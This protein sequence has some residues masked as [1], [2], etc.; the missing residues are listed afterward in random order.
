MGNLSTINPNRGGVIHGDGESGELGSVITNGLAGRESQI[1]APLL[2]EE[3]YSQ[4]RI[5]TAT[6]RATRSAKGGLSS[7]V[8]FLMEL[9]GDGVSRLSN[10]GV[11]VE[12][13][14]VRTTDDNTVVLTSGGSGG[15]WR[16][17]RSGGWGRG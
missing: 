16:S 1:D 7:G 9:E 6:H 11:W 12:Q 14:G 17:G 15:R 10:N 4:S 8:V 3:G 5:E 13:E 2:P